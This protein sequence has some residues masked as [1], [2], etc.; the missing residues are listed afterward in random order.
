MTAAGEAIVA[1]AR[2][3]L[4]AVGDLLASAGRAADPMKGTLRIA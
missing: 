3:I 1:E 4:L 2:R